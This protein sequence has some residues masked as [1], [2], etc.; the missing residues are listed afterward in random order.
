MLHRKEMK[1]K[2]YA[3]KHHNGSLC[4]QKQPVTA[5]LTAAI[6]KRDSM[7]AQLHIIQ[8]YV[9][10]STLYNIDEAFLC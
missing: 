4:T 9:T 1:R 2:V 7:G 10:S 8:C 3:A 5:A 6:R